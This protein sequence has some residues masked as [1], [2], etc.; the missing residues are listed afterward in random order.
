M[1]TIKPL[2]KKAVKEACKSKL[3]VS[4]EEHNIIGGLGSAISEYKSTIAN[5]PKQLFIGIEDT[6]GKGG[7][8]KFLK[9]KHGLT[10]SKVVSQILLNI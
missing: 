3:I 5:S 1:H 6:Y 4:A 8:Y 7:E 9:E 10:S 2:D